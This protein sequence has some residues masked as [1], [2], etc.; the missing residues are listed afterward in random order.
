[1]IAKVK[2]YYWTAFLTNMASC[3]LINKA[4]DFFYVSL[5]VKHGR[6]PPPDTLL[7]STFLTLFSYS[8]MTSSTLVHNL[9]NGSFF[10]EADVQ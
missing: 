6:S 3:S 2:K 10:S 7:R 5:P 9:K 4:S 8:K 1:M